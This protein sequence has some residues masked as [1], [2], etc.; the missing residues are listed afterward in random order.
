MNCFEGKDLVTVRGL[1]RSDLDLLFTNARKMEAIAK[2]GTRSSLLNDK[3]LG[4]M[5]FQVSTRTRMSFESAM[6]RLGG[7]TVGFADPKTTRAGDYYAESLNDMVHMMENYADVL[8]IRHPQDG[9]AAEAARIAD[10]PVI[11]AGDGYNE[12]PT[13]A[14]LDLYT[15]LREMGRLDDLKVGMVGDLNIRVHHSLALGLAL[16]NTKAYFISP[17]DVTMPATWLEEFQQVGLDFEETSSLEEVIEDLDVI[18]LLPVRSPS[19]SVGRAEAE[20]KR[21]PLPQ[22]FVLDEGKLGKV[23]PDAIVLH[24]LPRTEELPPEN[25]GHPSARYFEQAYYGVPVRMA[26][27]AMILGRTLAD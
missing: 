24:P 25:D 2:G 7:A 10:R 1:E 21:I 13:Q 16:Y 14:L 11:N 9:A 22:E 5:F 17:P 23:K 12:H 20:T 3:M 8:V 4:L 26:L 19:Y 27:L 15:I 6:K 18:Y